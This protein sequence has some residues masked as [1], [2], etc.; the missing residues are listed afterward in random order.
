MTFGRGWEWEGGGGGFGHDF[1]VVMSWEVG[2]F[3]CLP[4]YKRKVFR[5]IYGLLVLFS[6]GKLVSAIKLHFHKVFREL[7]V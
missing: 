3:S 4:L 2:S 5:F 6:S 1:T 7:S